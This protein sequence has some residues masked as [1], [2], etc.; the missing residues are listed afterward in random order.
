MI[1][2][3][4]VMVAAE[5]AILETN[6]YFLKTNSS[7]RVNRMSQEDLQWCMHISR[8]SSFTLEWSNVG[9]DIDH[10]EHYN[11]CFKMFFNGERPSGCCACRY[12]P[13]E[14]KVVIEMLQSFANE[15]DELDGRMTA[16]TLVTLLYFLKEISGLG[17]FIENPV[18]E[19]ILQHYMRNFHFKDVFGDGS[20]L[21]KSAD[22]LA[23]LV[24]EWLE[25]N[26]CI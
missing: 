26:Q 15:G 7:L 17:I 24:P 6:D 13:M 9:Q 4:S 22:D 8:Q 2:T 1:S 25:Q 16:Y 23:Y 10:Y 20:L 12:I 14:R 3:V 18:N 5:I 21:Y 19:V 11:F